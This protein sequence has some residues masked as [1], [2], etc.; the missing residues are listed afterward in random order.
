MLLS[1]GSSVSILVAKSCAITSD[2]YPLNSTALYITKLCALYIT[3][4]RAL[5]ITKLRALYVYISLNSSG[6]SISTLVAIPCVIEIESDFHRLTGLYLI[7]LLVTKP[8]AVASDDKLAQL[9]Q[10]LIARHFK[11]YL[12]LCV[13]VCER[14]CAFACLFVYVCVCACVCVCMCACGCVRLCRCVCVHVIFCL[15]N[16]M[17]LFIYYFI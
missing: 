13:G 8:Y 7:I 12:C 11:R 2:L 5:Y 16:L 1:T 3:K 15:H 17:N 10:V 4:L 6:S 14:A 9:C